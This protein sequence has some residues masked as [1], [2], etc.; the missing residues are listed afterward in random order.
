MNMRV[1]YMYLITMIG[2]MSELQITQALCDKMFN[3]ILNTSVYKH[4]C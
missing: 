3:E 2:K 1:N 4:V